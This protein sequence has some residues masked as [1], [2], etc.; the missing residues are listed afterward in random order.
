M[1]NKAEENKNSRKGRQA[2]PLSALRIVFKQ[3]T[4][5]L[6]RLRQRIIERQS[7]LGYLVRLSELPLLT[8]KLILFYREKTSLGKELASVPGFQPPAP[9]DP[10]EAW[11]AANQWTAKTERYLRERL[12]EDV[13]PLA[14]ISVVMPVYNPPLIFL[15]AAISSVI[16]Q[17]YDNW[18]LCI[19]DDFSP[20]PDIQLALKAWADR[21]DRIRLIL[22]EENG[23]ISA[24]T[25]SAASLATGEF[26]LFLDHD[27]E[28]TPDALGEI[29]LYLKNHPETDFVYSDDDKINTQGQRYAPQFK[30]DWSPELLLS[31]MYMGHVCAVR[32][33]IFDQVDGIRVGFEGSQDYDFALRATEKCRQV[34]HLPL[35][36]YHWRAVEGSTATSGAAKPESFLAAKEALQ[37]TLERRDLSGIVY[38]PEWAQAA[39]CGIFAYYFA[40]DGPS[41]SIIIPTKNQL[42]LLRDCIESLE[43]TTYKNYQIVIIDNES[44]DP[45]TLDYLNSI[46]HT[47]LEIGN[48]GQGFNFAAINN[49]AAELVNSDYLLFMNNDVEAISPQW[50]SQMVGFA[51]SSKVGAV[52]ARLLYPDCKIQHA[53]VIHGLHH[54]LAGHAFKLVPSWD[55]GYLSYAKVSRNYSAVTAAC[56][57]TPRELFLDSGGFDSDQFAVAYNDADYCYRLVEAGYRCVYCSTAELFHKEG[58]TRGFR[59]N[60]QEIAAFKRKYASKVDPF[61]SPHLSLEDE[62]F[63][64]VPRKVVFEISSPVKTLVF[65]HNLNW[66]GA[67][68]HQC[69]LTISLMKSG[70]IEPIVYAP[71]DG[72]LRQEYESAGITVYVR[73]HPLQGVFRVENYCESL[74][75]LADFI[76]SQSIELVYGNTISTFYA[77]AAAH[78]ANVPS[79]WNIHE[80]EEWEFHLSHFGTQLLAHALKSFQFPYRVIFVADATRDRYLPL[81][82]HHNFSVIHNGLNLER[83]EPSQKAMT[84]KTARH[85]LQVTEG[86]IVLLSLGTICERKGQHDLALALAKLPLELHSRI[87]VFM[88]GDRPS[89]YSTKLKQLIKQLPSSV[90]H[91]VSVVSETSNVVDYYKAA[92]IFVFTSRIESFPRV[93]LE[94]MACGLPIITTPV[95]GVKEQVKEGINALFYEPGEIDQLAEKIKLMLDDEAI[96]LAF[97]CSSYSVLNSLNTFEEMTEGYASLFREAYFSK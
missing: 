48:E 83:L 85:S 45:E 4:Y 94:A 36:L 28:L 34:G 71:E 91:R 80:S 87:R 17:V 77:I 69:E 89:Q 39:S 33:T 24:A 74:S 68:Y 73:P 23:N 58:T 53:G 9:L 54:G 2:S 56:L 16:S 27:D 10:Y 51:S 15:E 20:N 62:Q 70:V 8:K 90:R 14:K 64:I 7:R 78:Q 19:A 55:N 37:E 95:F 35:V 79:I 97:G 30:P 82:T 44:D 5:F 40:D 46:P 25:N 29:A 42:C 32:R 61:Y 59:D 47:V 18:E 43:K 22:R 60:P 38:H 50:L 76:K 75:A 52:G 65:T 26:I 6:A 72:P 41:V 63:K 57:L 84:R 1:S 96:R 49:R 66:E 3:N 13:S 11:Q 81:N 86:D 31:Y 93:I 67:T 88:V 21:D 12:Q 92:D